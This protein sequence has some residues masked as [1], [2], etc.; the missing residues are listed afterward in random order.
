MTLR[1]ATNVAKL[2]LTA[3]SFAS[4]QNVPGGSQRLCWAAPPG[5]GQ[6]LD[7]LIAHNRASKKK[8]Y[9][10][11]CTRGTVYWFVGINI[12]KSNTTTFPTQSTRNDLLF[13]W[14]KAIKLHSYALEYIPGMILYYSLFTYAALSHLHNT[15]SLTVS[16][17]KA[18]Q[19]PVFS[20]ICTLS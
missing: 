14:L 11:L 4:P 8:H 15:K 3:S 19:S 5:R 20:S 9:S 1:W 10:L 16:D 6:E 12:V 7:L 18:P 2:W 17:H 13:L